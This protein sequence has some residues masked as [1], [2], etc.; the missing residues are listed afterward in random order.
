MEKLRDLLAFVPK[1]QLEN[2]CLDDQNNSELETSGTNSDDDA[3]PNQFKSRIQIIN[4]LSDKEYDPNDCRV[5]NN[6][7][8]FSKKYSQFHPHPL[9]LHSEQSHAVS[10][11]VSPESIIIDGIRLQTNSL[12]EAMRLIRA[13]VQYRTGNESRQQ[14]QNSSCG[15]GDQ[16]EDACS[17][18]TPSF[19]DT[20]PTARININ[21]SHIIIQCRLV[22]VTNTG[23]EI[24]PSE[25]YLSTVSFVDLSHG[26]PVNSTLNPTIYQEMSSITSSLTALMS[27]IQQIQHG[28]LVQMRNDIAL[29]QS[30]TQSDQLLP[31]QTDI[32]Y[33]MSKL[34]MILKDSLTTS[35]FLSQ[36]SLH[37][38][39]FQ[40]P[41]SNS[42]TKH[43][44]KLAHRVQNSIY[45]EPS[46]VEQG[47]KIGGRIEQNEQIAENRDAVSSKLPQSTLQKPMSSSSTDLTTVNKATTPQQRVTAV[48]TNPSSIAPAAAALTKKPPQSSTVPAAASSSK[49]SNGPST[50]GNQSNTARLAGSV[51]TQPV[52]TTPSLPSSNTSN[53][54]TRRPVANS[55]TQGVNMTAKLANNL[56][57]K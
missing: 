7:S 22:Q 23:T 35:P 29:G 5:C 30:L 51:K 52:G 28:K 17:C 33:R 11:Q 53:P 21:A 25:K 32:N 45:C 40:F 24:N 47:E 42:E 10:H 46:V 3:L 50:L 19:Y 13:A 49:S 54:A 18:K 57:K 15:S 1:N 14:C 2:I 55:T 6:A 44:L 36:L 34:T 31:H 8:L 38:S 41:G 48:N 12:T 43:L 20:T 9:S 39:F 26:F 37:F 4:S 27:T 16:N 56:T